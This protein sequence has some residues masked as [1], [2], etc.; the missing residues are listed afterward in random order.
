MIGMAVGKALF[1]Q[2]MTAVHGL[3]WPQVRWRVI[4]CAADEKVTPKWLK[5]DTFDAFLRYLGATVTQPAAVS[6]TLEFLTRHHSFLLGAIGIFQGFDLGV[7]K[8]FDW[9][10]LSKT[11]FGK[12]NLLKSSW[13][14]SQRCWYLS[15]HFRS[16]AQIIKTSNLQ[17]QKKAFWNNLLEWSLLFGVKNNDD[18]AKSRLSLS[19]LSHYCQQVSFKRARV[20]E[21]FCPAD[22]FEPP[23]LVTLW[24]MTWLPGSPQMELVTFLHTLSLTS[25][26]M[27]PLCHYLLCTLWKLS[28]WEE[29]GSLAGFGWVWLPTIQNRWLLDV[30]DVVVWPHKAKSKKGLQQCCSLIWVLNFLAASLLWEKRLAHR[31]FCCQI[32]GNLRTEDALFQY[33]PSWQIFSQR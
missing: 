19:S 17:F 33:V 12:Q 16:I 10:K 8:R 23:L 29:G 22:K 30:S 21:I 24:P 9:V 2:F 6:H 3:R 20:E 31:R 14:T 18:A 7:S 27:E 11:L 26:W 28:N 32:R 15:P 4:A 5:G 1:V 13:L 25:L